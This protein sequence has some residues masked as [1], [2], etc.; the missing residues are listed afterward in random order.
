MYFKPIAQF[1]LDFMDII[2]IFINDQKIN[3]IYS[4]VDL[5]IPVDEYIIVRIN[6]LKA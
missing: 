2:H 5:F 4:V 6:E 3:Y 1:V